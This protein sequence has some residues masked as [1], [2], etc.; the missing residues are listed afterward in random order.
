MSGICLTIPK[1]C[2]AHIASLIW[3]LGLTRDNEYKVP[4]PKIEYL[5]DASHIAMD[6]T[7][8]DLCTVYQLP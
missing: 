8:F 3:Y 2:S 5:S 7:A 1:R 6:E 4:A